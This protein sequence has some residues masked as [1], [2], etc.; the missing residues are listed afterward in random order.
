M[1][2]E[3]LVPEE[4]LDEMAAYYRARAPQYTAWFARREPGA[5]GPAENVH[6][7][8]EVGTVFTA[9]DELA[10][11]GDVI[12]LAARSGI[13]TARLLRTATSVTAV[14]LSPEMLA[15]NRESVAD[16][17]VR[18]VLADLFARTPDRTYDGVSFGF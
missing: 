12:E 2:D 10:M 17:R 1:T 5:R 18:Y 13:W 6:W 16:A 8:A 11:A 4:I 9:L 3:H 14:D 15:L 7:F